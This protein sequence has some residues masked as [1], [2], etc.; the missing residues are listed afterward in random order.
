MPNYDT[1]LQIAD[2]VHYESSNK[3]LII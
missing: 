3:I 2:L 1:A